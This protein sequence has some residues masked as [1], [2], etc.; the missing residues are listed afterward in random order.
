M[1]AAIFAFKR[2][3]ESSLSYAGGEHLSDKVGGFDAVITRD[4]FYEVTEEIR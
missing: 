4:E 2:F 3:E 1:N